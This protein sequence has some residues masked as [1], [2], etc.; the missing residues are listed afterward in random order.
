MLGAGYI[1]LVGTVNF[2][3]IHRGAILQN[4]STVFKIGAL[5]LLVLV[6]FALGQQ[7]AFPTGGMLGHRAS[8]ALSPFLLAM[9]W[10]LGAC[11]G[12]ADLAL[13][14]GEVLHPEMALPRAFLIGTS[15]VFVLY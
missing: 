2:F 11:D 15:I 12:G 14:G 8:R 13:V 6:G 9:V 3:G 10:I 5:A 4:L 7:A 1:L